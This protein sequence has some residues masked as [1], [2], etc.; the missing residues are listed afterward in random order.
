MILNTKKCMVFVAVAAMV[1]SLSAC[2]KNNNLFHK[3]ATATAA[4]QSPDSYGM[5]DSS[6]WADQA[7]QGKLLVKGQKIG[8]QTYFFAFDNDTV[9]SKYF[10]N[11]N[12]QAEFL[13]MHPKAK[14]RLEGNTDERGSREYN[15]GL[16][17]RRSQAVSRLLEQQGVAPKQLDLLSFGKEKPLAYGNDPTAW[18]KN[19]RVHLVYEVY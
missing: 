6:Q 9:A 8:E 12:A 17:W 14:V 13:I 10:G 15:I 11:I 7:A 16:G 5:G 1:L 18:S 3:N 2:G 19:R 4:G